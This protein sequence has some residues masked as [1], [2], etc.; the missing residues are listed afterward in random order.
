MSAIA[1][2]VKKDNYT[3]AAAVTPSDS[4]EV[5]FSALYIG[6]AGAVAV[7][8]AGGDTVTFAAVPVGTVLEVAVVKVLSTGTA[9]TNIVGLK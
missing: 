3:G 9:A 8:T 4:T 1:V 6:G 7:E 2:Q 5:Q